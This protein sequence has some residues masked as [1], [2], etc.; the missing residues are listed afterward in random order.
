MSERL[1]NQWGALT[2]SAMI[3]LASICGPVIEVLSV[4]RA[5]KLALEAA[6]RAGDENP[7]DESQDQHTIIV[8]HCCEWDR[9]AKASIP[10]PAL[11]GPSSQVVPPTRPL[12]PPRFVIARDV[13]APATLLA[14]SGPHRN[15]APHAPPSVTERPI[16]EHSA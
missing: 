1:A 8:P 15:H 4:Q 12:H 16:S 10:I 14:I 13:P 7:E 9:V 5:L 2:L 6:A 11:R 3:G